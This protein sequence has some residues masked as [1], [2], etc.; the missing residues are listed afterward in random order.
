MACWRGGEGWLPQKGP[1]ISGSQCIKNKSLLKM[2]ALHFAPAFVLLLLPLV[3]QS[4]PSVLDTTFS[5]CCS[6]CCLLFSVIALIRS[7]FAEAPSR[8][9]LLS[10]GETKMQ[11]G[12]TALASESSRFNC[13]ARDGR[14]RQSV[15][16][17]STKRQRGS[18][19]ARRAA[20]QRT[21]SAGCSERG[22]LGILGRTGEKR[23]KFC[24]CF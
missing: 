15:G 6:D 13:K 19:L 20:A 9:D 24:S 7:H 11:H 5:E 4:M 2:S 17:R 14:W 10:V 1:S 12:S 8:E 21:S 22:K 16:E 18:R 23:R 3:S